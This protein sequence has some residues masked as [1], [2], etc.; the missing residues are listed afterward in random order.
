MPKAP[1]KCAGNNGTCPQLI[2]HANYCPEHQ[3]T[4]SWAGR[5]TGQG[6]TNQWRKTRL[7]VLQRDR[8]QCQLRYDGCT[9]YA[10]EVDH[11]D[12]IATTGIPRPQALN[13]ERL[14]AVCHPCHTNRTQ[15]QAA[16]A[17]RN[18]PNWRRQPEHHPGLLK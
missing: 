13:P 2:R 5:T 14:R 17:R 12:G 16:T 7:L 8:H 1:R 15:Q 11:I 9:G 10:T 4:N 6:S 3:R 18:R